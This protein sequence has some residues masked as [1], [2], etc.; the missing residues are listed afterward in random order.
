MAFQEVERKHDGTRR[1]CK[2]RVRIHSIGTTRLTIR[3]AGDIHTDLG[4]PPFYSV[5]IGTGEDAGKIALTPTQQR[6]PSAYTANMAK[7]AKQ[8]QITISLG[9][10]GLPAG[11]RSP[12][13]LPFEL[14][15]GRLIIDITSIME[16]DAPANVS[17][18]A[19][20]TK[21]LAAAE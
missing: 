4:Q 5:A 13:D 18:D 21:H 15:G 20:L 10:L 16:P 12:R 8:A 7:Q 11:R 14:I 17:R 19:K 6:S 1:A 3:I 2:N 9:V